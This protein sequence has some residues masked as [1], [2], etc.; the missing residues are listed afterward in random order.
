M[1]QRLALEAQYPW[2]AGE[3]GEASKSDNEN[4]VKEILA[5]H[6]EAMERVAKQHHEQLKALRKERNAHHMKIVAK[7]SATMDDIKSQHS[8]AIEELTA[9]EA[10]KK[11][12]ASGAKGEPVLF[13]GPVKGGFREDGKTLSPALFK[14]ENLE[15]AA[16]SDFYRCKFMDHVVSGVMV[17]GKDPVTHKVG[18]YLKCTPPT[19]M[20]NGV[21][22]PQ[23]V[24]VKGSVDGGESWFGEG[25]TYTYPTLDDAPED[26]PSSFERY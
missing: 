26:D 24:T 3:A 1:H 25:I 13:P 6:Q 4:H 16:Q 12:E 2:E 11:A 5:Q 8:Q 14:S 18:Q 17:R 22:M 21:L 23:S 20:E 10:E 15:T 9:K 7:H 19:Q